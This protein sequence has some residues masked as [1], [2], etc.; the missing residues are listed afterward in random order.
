MSSHNSCDG[1]DSNQTDV[2]S[3]QDIVGI[4]GLFILIGVITFILLLSFLI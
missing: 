1:N 3:N 2:I 4:Q